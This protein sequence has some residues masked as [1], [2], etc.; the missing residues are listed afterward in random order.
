ML[1]LLIE[2][3]STIS[4]STKYSLKLCFLY[5]D[6]F[7]EICIGSFSDNICNFAVLV[8]LPKFLTGIRYF[9]NEILYAFSRDESYN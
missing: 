6:T 7:R 3:F 1:Q 8:F 5:I 2:I 4:F 9:S